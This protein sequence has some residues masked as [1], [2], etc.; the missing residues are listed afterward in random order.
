MKARWVIP[1]LCYGPFLA[2]EF[3]I[4]DSTLRLDTSILAFA[5]LYVFLPLLAFLFALLLCASNAGLPLKFLFPAVALVGVLSGYQLIETGGI[6]RDGLNLTHLSADFGL[7]L[8]VVFS[9]AALGTAA[10]FIVRAIGKREKQRE[11]TSFRAQTGATGRT[12]IPRLRQNV[13]A[14]PLTVHLNTARRVRAAAGM[15]RRAGM[16]APQSPRPKRRG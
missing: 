3:L 16:T 4:I 11:Q 10:G 14:P 5:S 9:P 7:A 13:K 1:A 12:R 6:P 8:L 15:G 2:L